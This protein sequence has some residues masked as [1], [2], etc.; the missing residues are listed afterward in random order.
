[1]WLAPQW[2][3]PPFERVE[4]RA[5]QAHDLL[6]AVEHEDAAK[7]RNADDHDIAI[8]I[9][10]IGGRAAG[11]PGVRCLRYDDYARAGAG[12]EYL[13][14]FEPGA[15]AHHRERLAAAAAEPGADAA[16]GARGGPDRAR[17]SQCTAQRTC[18]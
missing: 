5:R 11:E 1:M 4:R 14:L 8:I 15:G 3:Q 13:P 12:I 18:N 10:A 7:P 16:G 17:V 2:L 9:T 6:S